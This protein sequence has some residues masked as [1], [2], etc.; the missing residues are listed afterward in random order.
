MAL[1]HMEIVFMA[2]S[3]M[4]IASM[5]LTSIFNADG[6]RLDGPNHCARSRGLL[7]H[8]PGTPLLGIQFRVG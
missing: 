3:Q 5:T 6:D 8:F 4:D 1:S 7:R 2:L